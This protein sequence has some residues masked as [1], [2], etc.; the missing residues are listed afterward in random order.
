MKDKCLIC[1]E[2][3]EIENGTNSIKCTCPNCGNYKY[4]GPF[5]PNFDGEYRYK[6]AIYLFYHKKILE[7]GFFISERFENKLGKEYI[8]KDIVE[9]WFPKNFAEKI[10]YI[11]LYLYNLQSYEGESLYFTENQ[12]KKLFFINKNTAANKNC[13]D[14][15]LIYF[16]LYLQRSNLITNDGRLSINEIIPKKIILT[17]TA[18][19]Q[20]YK[21]QKSTNLSKQA[22]VAM[23]FSDD[24]NDIRNSIKKACQ[25]ANFTPILIDDYLH[26]K[27]IVPEIFRLIR[28]TR[29]L[30]MD[31]SK[32]N[33]GAYFEA[34]YAQGIG[35]EVIIT[36]KKEIFDGHFEECEFNDNCEYIKKLLKP[37]FDIAQK[38]ILIW[39][40]YADLEFRLEKWI[41]SI[42]I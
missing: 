41:N 19:N 15:Q 29:F 14:E 32:P 6:L 17:P 25:K 42:I 37:H 34:G 38:Q 35:K 40:D 9:N 20:I 33:Y 10:D 18:L 7:N 5:S 13:I 2:I 28:E 31:I 1:E 16:Y 30:I 11:L 36:C 27:Q 4:L 8:S 39:T 12:Y 23:E 3:C 21:L 26:G 22:F 24:T